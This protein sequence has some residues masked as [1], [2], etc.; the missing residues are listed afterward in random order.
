MEIGCTVD[1]SSTMA[2]PLAR[3]VRRFPLKC[4]L[5]LVGDDRCQDSELPGMAVSLCDKGGAKIAIS[6]AKVDTKSAI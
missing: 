6:G 1:A 3:E 4:P 2:V 5:S